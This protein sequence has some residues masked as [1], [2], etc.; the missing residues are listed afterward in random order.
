MVS[1]AFDAVFR[2]METADNFDYAPLPVFH[3]ERT[4]RHRFWVAEDLVG[5][6]LANSKTFN[7]F[8]GD[9]G[10]PVIVCV[11]GFSETYLHA[12]LL[13]WNSKNR[14]YNTLHIR[15]GSYYPEFMDKEKTLNYVTKNKKRVIAVLSLT[16]LVRLYDGA[17]LDLEVLRDL[18]Q[19]RMS[20]K[21]IRYSCQ[22]QNCMTFSMLAF[23]AT[24][25]D[26]DKFLEN[27][28]LGTLQSPLHIIQAL[29]Q[30]KKNHPALHVPGHPNPGIAPQWLMKIN[31][32]AVFAGV[33]E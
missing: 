10:D 2:A 3:P 6:H 7:H 19:S 13:F 9:M 26:L 28:G 1:S 29:A 11:N 14:E 32:P 18:F 24:N 20:I 17:R 21:E 30:S 33:R 22:S 31:Q 4:R 25:L 15:Q 5:S 12:F 16:Q 23:R 8:I 27:T